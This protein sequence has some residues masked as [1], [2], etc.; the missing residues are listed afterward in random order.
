[1][2]SEGSLGICLATPHFVVVVADADDLGN[3]VELCTDIDRDL[4]F[5]FD[6]PSL[7]GDMR[8]VGLRNQP[9]VAA[10]DPGFEAI[11]TR[12]SVLV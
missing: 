1:M 2:L 9:V 5:E 6:R 7:A 11:R 10:V 8:S 3:L 4:R 12:G